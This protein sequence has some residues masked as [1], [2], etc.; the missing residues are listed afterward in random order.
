MAEATDGDTMPTDKLITP[1]S[2]DVTAVV[3]DSDPQ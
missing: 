2:F 1:I 3:V